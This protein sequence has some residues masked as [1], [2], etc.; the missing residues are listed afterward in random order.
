MDTAR[1]IGDGGGGASVRRLV[2]L[3]DRDPLRLPGAGVELAANLVGL[4]AQV[5]TDLATTL[6]GGEQRGNGSGH[7][8]EHEPEEEGA[9]MTL[10]LAF[11]QTGPRR[12]GVD[13][14]LAGRDGRTCGADGEGSTLPEV[15]EHRAQRRAPRLLGPSGG[16]SAHSRCALRGVA[17][18]W[19]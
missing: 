3:E 10:L 11:A 17:P 1:G 14:L 6:R 9:P 12:G 19:P 15:V 4:D 2:A 18:E 13:Q 16:L 5:V 7:G 8:P